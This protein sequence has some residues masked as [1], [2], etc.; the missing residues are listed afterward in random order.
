MF[1]P[2]TTLYLGITWFMLEC[3]RFS[4]QQDAFELT[5]YP[6]WSDTL[7]LVSQCSTSSDASTIVGPDGISDFE[8]VHYWHGISLDPPELLCCSDLKSNPFLIPSPG[9]RWFTL[10]VKT[11]HEVFNT[12]LNPVWHIVAP[13]IIDLFKKRDIKY[14]SLMT[15]CFTTEHDGKKTLGPIVIWIATHPGTTTTQNACDSSPD[16]LHILEDNGVNG[17]VVEWYE[18][19]VERLAG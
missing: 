6:T 16:I 11:A 3:K 17:A 13:L 2:L 8:R 1:I 4:E 19:S 18:G 15:V 9:T 14:S 7:A 5:S 10:P 12:A